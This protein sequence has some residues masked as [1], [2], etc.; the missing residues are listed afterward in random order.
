MSILHSRAMMTSSLVAIPV[1]SKNL[2]DLYPVR[3]QE[4]AFRCLRPRCH[5]AQHPGRSGK[6]IDKCP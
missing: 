5:T 3:L 4:Q 2:G 6:N 1:L